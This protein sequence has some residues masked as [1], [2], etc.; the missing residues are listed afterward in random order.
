V[1]VGT[2]SQSVQ[3]EHSHLD[4]NLPTHKLWSLLQQNSNCVVGHMVVSNGRNTRLSNSEAQ[5]FSLNKLPHLVS[6]HHGQ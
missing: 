4:P 5:T 6:L 1:L 3:L 2:F